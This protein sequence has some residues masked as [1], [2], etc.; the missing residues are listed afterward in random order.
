MK[1]SISTRRYRMKKFAVISFAGSLLLV[2]VFFSVTALADVSVG[3]TIVPPAVVIPA[4]PAVMVI[5]GTY[6]YFIP[7]VEADMLFYGGWWYR[8]YRG[9]WYRARGYNGP[10]VHV[11]VSRV[12]SVVI[13]VPPHFRNVPPGHT[14]IPYG[15]LK[16]NWRTWER[17]RHWDR[18]RE[19]GREREIRKEHGGEGRGHGRGRH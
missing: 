8:P 13:N 18:G 2:A 14:R 4:P 11:G 15:Q 1:K 17:E 5:P 12:P 7:D 3:I 6:V 9:Y 19:R 10:W 16:K